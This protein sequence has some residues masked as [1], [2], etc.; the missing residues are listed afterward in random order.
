MDTVCAT[1]LCVVTGFVVL[2]VLLT[3]SQGETQASRRDYQPRNSNFDPLDSPDASQRRAGQI[4]IVT[5]NPV[6]IIAAG[7]NIAARVTTTR[8]ATYSRH[9]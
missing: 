1:G 9:D 5:Q 3:G 8:Q 4:L 2:A 6:F 7:W